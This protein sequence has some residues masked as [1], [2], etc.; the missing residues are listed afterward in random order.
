MVLWRT[1]T[2]RTVF[3][4]L[5]NSFVWPWGTLALGTIVTALATMGALTG[6]LKSP[7]ALA[8]LMVSFG[9]Y[10]I[11]HL[12]L[13]ETLTTRYALP[14]V[15]PI[16][17]LCVRGATALRVSPF[18]EIAIIAAGLVM[19]VP[20]ARAFG[21]GSPGFAAMG[22]AL[23]RGGLVSGHAG[24][25]R[26]WEWMDDG[27]SGARF[28]R[29]PHGHEW[30][31]LVEEWQK[32]PD[33]KIQFLAN[34]RRTDYRTLIDPQAQRSSVPYRWPFV[35]WPNLGGA[36][37]DAVTR[38]E[39]PPPGW[40][41]DRGWAVSAEVAG[42][43]EVD[44]YGPHRKPSVAW[45]R[46]RDAGATLMLGGRHLGVGADEPQARIAV[47]L[48]GAERDRLTVGPGYFFRTIDLPPGTLAGS[49]YIPLSISRIVQRPG[50]AGSGRPRTV[51]PPATRGRNGWRFD[52]LV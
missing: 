37:P 52:R 26:L 35:S 20:Q 10:A 22:D 44:G 3:H 16:A 11:F 32:N 15:I 50:S 9:P 48:N 23:S 39:L 42:V 19:A 49:G 12:L 43:T 14:L 8:V 31:T 5:V 30:L 45:I 36:R 28:L 7:K 40:I 47:T 27:K 4:A 34:P 25:R 21:K 18:A 29:A 46:A 17:Y 33:A 38:I 24:M 51:R 13:Q 2:A 41:L 6:V 1:L